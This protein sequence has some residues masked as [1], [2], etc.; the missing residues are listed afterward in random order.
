M[1]RIPVTGGKYPS[2]LG[3]CASTRVYVRVALTI[4]SLSR[5]YLG[6]HMYTLIPHSIFMILQSVRWWIF[7]V[8]IPHTTWRV[9]VLGSRG[10]QFI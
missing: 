8:G 10:H 6:S 4:G 3:G 7:R 1:I 5:S 2:V 9:H